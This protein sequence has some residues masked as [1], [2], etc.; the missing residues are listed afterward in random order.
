MKRRQFTISIASLAGLSTLVGPSAFAALDPRSE[1]G[2]SDPLMARSRFEGRLG[3]KFTLRDGVVESTLLLNDVKSAVR[4]HDQEQFHVLF[5]APE[6]QV[7]HE[8][9]Y[10]LQAPAKG[11]VCCIDKIFFMS[12][13]TSM[14][15]WQEISPPL[16]LAITNCI[17]WR[18]INV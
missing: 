17:L 15:I 2:I 7:L 12:D 14:L 16:N 5:E 1:N 9:I 10:F 13:D 11:L 18:S 6:G 8:G 3:Q 4:G